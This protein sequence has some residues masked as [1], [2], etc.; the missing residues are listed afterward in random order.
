[1]LVP[2][3]NKGSANFANLNPFM[4]PG[5]ELAH[6]VHSTLQMTLPTSPCPT[7]SADAE[8]ACKHTETIFSVQCTL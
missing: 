5:R 4:Q 1:M 7:L 6:P 8:L 3:M 2:N